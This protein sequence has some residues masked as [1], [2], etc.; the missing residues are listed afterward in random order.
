MCKTKAAGVTLF[1]EYF[2]KMDAMMPRI[3]KPRDA[4]GEREYAMHYNVGFHL[5]F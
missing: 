5:G 2:E 4:S 1:T 3:L